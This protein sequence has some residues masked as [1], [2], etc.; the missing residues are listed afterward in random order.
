MHFNTI[1]TSTFDKHSQGVGHWNTRPIL[2]DLRWT[3]PQLQQVD[4]I[5]PKTGPH[6]SLKK[7]SGFN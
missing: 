6:K 7:K 1:Q 5:F 3:R 2:C 4:R